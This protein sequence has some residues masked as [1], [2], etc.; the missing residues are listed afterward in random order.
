[1]AR[2]M[3]ACVE[4]ST[5][6]NKYLCFDSGIEGYETESGLSFSRSNTDM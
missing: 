1:M 2:S 5:F 4:M 6:V 3:N